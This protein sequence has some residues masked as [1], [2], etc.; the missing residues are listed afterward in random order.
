[1]FNITAGS[2]PVTI[3]RFSANLYAGSATYEI[4]YRAGTYVGY[5]SNAAAWTLIGSC[6]GLAGNPGQPTLI[7]INVNVTIPANTT[8]G[9]YVTNTASGGLNYTSSAVN[10]VTLFSNTDLS[11]IGGVGKA[12]PFSATYSFRLFNGTAH[13]YIGNIQNGTLAT[14]NTTHTNPAQSNNSSNLYAPSCSGIICAVAGSGANPISGQTTSKVW[15][16]A[17]A[18][19][20]F[21]R[22]HYEITPV[23]NPTTATGRVTL[24]F[25][26]ADFDAFNAINVVKLPVGPTDN[27]GKANLLVEKR[28]GTS[29]DGSGHPSTYTGSISNINPTDADIVWDATNSRWAVTFDVVGFSG[30]YVKTQGGVLPVRWLD[31]HG[32]LIGNSH[33]RIS[34][35]VQEQRVQTYIVEGSAD[36]TQ[37][38]E[39]GRVN[40]L[41]DGV[42]AYQFET[43]S[44]SANVRLFRIKQL[45][46]DLRMS[47]SNIIRLR[48]TT[49]Q[50]QVAPNPANSQLTLQ[51]KEDQIKTIAYIHDQEG[52]I[53]NRIRIAGTS[54][55]IDIQSLPP[56]MY[57]IQLAN[58]EKIKW[59]KQ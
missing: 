27:V 33:A 9:F 48:G 49:N 40:S 12:Y 16:Q 30:F 21:V 31:V 28:S 57:Y 45:D 10:N 29:S 3:A 15:I 51:V 58:G 13:Y 18:P 4:Y 55:T 41:G 44:L 46:H 17:T 20:H 37:F 47:Y 11:I 52:R 8:Y 23:N 36:G 38:T 34:W 2:N 43:S 24:Y 19:A 1:M 42:H 59:I 54:Q 6:S 32:A 26:Q 25:T 5:E 50:S 39:L 56:G 7:P 22:R 14:T 53:V 35:K